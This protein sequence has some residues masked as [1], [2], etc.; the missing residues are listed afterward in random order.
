MLLT[1]NEPPEHFP[2]RLAWS[3]FRRTHQAVAQRCH[4]ARR[5]QRPPLS[6]HF[7]TVQVLSTPILELTDER[8]TRITPLLPP[9]GPRRGRPPNDHRTILAGMLW[10][11]RTGASWR[12]IP[13]HFGPWETV[14]SRYQLWRRMGIWERILA[15]LDGRECTD[16]LQMSL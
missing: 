11:V 13:A 5:A 4:A 14:H 8:W 1:L 12:E 15:V 2:F 10:V 3:T 6:H 16:D 9:P 7:P